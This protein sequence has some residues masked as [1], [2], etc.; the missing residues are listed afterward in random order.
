MGEIVGADIYLTE[1]IKVPERY[2]SP[3]HWKDTCL[4]SFSFG[5]IWGVQY[6]DKL[7]RKSNDYHPA[8]R[9]SAE[10]LLKR[11]KEQLSLSE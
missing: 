8:N 5:H 2:I 4:C 7:E 10:D 11:M 3:E 9:L 1:T 6:F